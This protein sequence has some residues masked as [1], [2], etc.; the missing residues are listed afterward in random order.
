M[1]SSCV[2]FLQGMSGMQMYSLAAVISLGL[3]FWSYELARWLAR[4]PK[5]RGPSGYPVVGNMWQIYGKDAPLQYQQWSKTFGPV[6]QI[7]LGNIPV[8]VINTASAA[9][10]ILTQNSSATA[11]RPEFYTFHKVWIVRS[12]CGGDCSN[13]NSDHLQRRCSDNWIFAIQRVAQEKTQSI[14]FGA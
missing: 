6:Y 7:Q 1:I 10:S 14:C 2:N 13:V 9:K 12:F 4:V 11:S 8:L 3:F 5:F